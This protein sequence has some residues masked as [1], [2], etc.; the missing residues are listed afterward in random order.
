MTDIENLP[1]EI[2]QLKIGDQIS[3]ENFG[4]LIQELGS[5]INYKLDKIYR[6][7]STEGAIEHAESNLE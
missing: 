7:F 6:K 5:T 2:D 3:S 4:E 1:I